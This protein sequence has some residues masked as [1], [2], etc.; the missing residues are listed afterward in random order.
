MHINGP[1]A[2]NKIKHYGEKEKVST[3]CEP[4]LHILAKHYERKKM[5]GMYLS[6]YHSV[7]ATTPTT[8]KQ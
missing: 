4:Y 8:N 2:H 6:K 3:C 7:H 5:L 1:L